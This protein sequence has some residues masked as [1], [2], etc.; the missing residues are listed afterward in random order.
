M[1][2][3][4][5]QR[6]STLNSPPPLDY[7]RNVPQLHRAILESI[8]KELRSNKVISPSGTT[9]PPVGPVVV[10]ATAF[11]PEPK[12]EAVS[13]TVPS[14]RRDSGATQIQHPKHYMTVGPRLRQGKQVPEQSAS[15][16][17]RS[18]IGR[19]WC[20]GARRASRAGFSKGGRGTARSMGTAIAH[21]PT[22]VAASRS[23]PRGR[24]A[25]RRAWA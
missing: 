14:K 4:P 11:E 5:P 23:K 20:R 12:K 18:S 17:D 15:R 9:A 6:G 3:F 21:F 8:E 24:H 7:P 1:S 10:V 2:T 19:S 25:T 13:S 16:A 22:A